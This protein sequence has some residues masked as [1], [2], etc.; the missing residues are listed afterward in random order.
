MSYVFLDEE[1]I[2]TIGEFL[3][4]DRCDIEIVRAILLILQIF[5]VF[6]SVAFIMM[7][8]EISV[9][10]YLNLRANILTAVNT[11]KNKE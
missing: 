7:I 1:R 11:S 3:S 2:R 8:F 5:G 9:S 4:L 6:V 10:N